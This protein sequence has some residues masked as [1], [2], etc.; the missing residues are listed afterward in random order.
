MSNVLKR[1]PSPAMVVALIALSVALAGGAVAAGNQINGALIKKNSMPGNR[2]KKNTFVPKATLAS[3]ARNATHA[4]KAD[5]ATHATSAD[6]ATN[7]N[8]ATTAGG[9]P[10]T[11]SA[12]GVLAGS[13]PNPTLASPQSETS[14]GALS[15]SWAAY[16]LPRTPTYYKDPLGVVRLSG[17][18]VS[19]TI[20]ADLGSTNVAFTLPA[21]NRPSHTIYEPVVTTNGAFA[22]TPGYVGIDVDGGVHIIVGNN[23]F[24]SLDGLTFRAAS[25]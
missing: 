21:G 22:L 11:G 19:G 20:S 14:V 25:S 5:S 16:D 2:V 15:N 12:G 10:P 6:N 18:I 7:A 8:H 23:T 13:Y 17:A 3:R 24:V 4:G 9:A 1:R